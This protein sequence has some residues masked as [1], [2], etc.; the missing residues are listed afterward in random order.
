MKNNILKAALVLLIIMAV[1]FSGCG[2]A[3]VANGAEDSVSSAETPASDIQESITE[4]EPETAAEA[5]DI[6][7]TE[8][9][10]YLVLDQEA[11]FSAFDPEEVVMTVNGREI[12]WNEFC[13]WLSV[14][15]DYIQYYMD[16]YSYYGMTYKWTD[17]A[18]EA[19]TLTVAE[20]VVSEAE[21]HV[22]MVCMIEEVAEENGIVLSAE[23][24][25]E[26]EENHRSEIVEY[27]GEDATEEDF[28][29]VLQEEHLTLELYQKFN[30]ANFL[31]R[32]NFKELYGA[33]GEKV[34]DEDALGYL[35]ENGCLHAAHILFMTVDSATDEA[36][37]DET[38]EAKKAQAE[39]AAAELQ[40]IT[41]REE[42]L[43][44]FRELK[45]AYCEDTGRFSYPDGYVFTRGTMVEEF[46]NTCLELEE[47]QVSDP[48]LTNYGYHIIMRLPDDP[49]AVIEYSSEG[50]ALNAR[51]EYANIAYSE[52]MQERL[53]QAEIVLK[54]NLQSFSILDYLVEAEG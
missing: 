32:K 27:C 47:Y 4:G 40:A 42:L 51:A 36:L 18:D 28:A 9:T 48:V 26:L 29:A 45:D 52:M 49:D 1:L 6:Q 39:K 3:E 30:K 34:S 54:E 21:N 7:D 41:D 35:K 24:E 11:M 13:Y 23:D 8:E 43:K 53:D 20:S 17:P 19:G 25:K 50:T 12:T 46:E 16:M 38:V 33:N 22:G 5:A 15:A 10:A 2:A 44:R 14:Y 31:Y 37:D